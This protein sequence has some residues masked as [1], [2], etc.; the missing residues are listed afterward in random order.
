MAPGTSS[1]AIAVST[2]MKLEY[3]CT[4]HGSMVGTVN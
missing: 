4:I 3:H 1:T 2:A